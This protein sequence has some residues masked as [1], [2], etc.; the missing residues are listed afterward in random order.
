[1]GWQTFAMRVGTVWEN[2]QLWLSMMKLAGISLAV[3]LG[4]LLLL[5]D[6]RTVDAGRFSMLSNFLKVFVAFLLGFFMSASV[7]AFLLLSECVR[8]LQM[9][10]HALGVRQERREL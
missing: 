4:T 2:R 6:P 3:A 8:N 5:R 10:L 9:Q 7:N 1:M